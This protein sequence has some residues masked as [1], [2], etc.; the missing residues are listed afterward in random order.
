M[1][2]PITA[3]VAA[4]ESAVSKMSTSIK[5]TNKKGKFMPLV[6]VMV[7]KESNSDEELADNVMAVY[8]P[9]EL[10]L[11]S[12]RQNVKSAL[13]KMTMGPPIK[14]GEAAKADQPKKE[15]K[16][17][18]EKEEVKEEAKEEI[19]EETPKGDEKK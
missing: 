13:V 12:K 18:L 1:P 14:I 16:K 10:G 11:P 3:N 6:H 7:G 8:K 17:P 5:I 19:K 2:K 9:V 15:E 4:F